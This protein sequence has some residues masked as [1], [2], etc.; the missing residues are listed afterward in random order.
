[1]K[2]Q[3]VIQLGA[4]RVDANS[5]VDWHL[6]GTSGSLERGGRIALGGL[7]GEVGAALAECETIV[8][9]PGELVFLTSAHIPSRQ[10]RQIKQALPYMVEELIADNIEDVHLAI[11]ELKPGD[12]HELPV[13][14]VQHH[15]LIDWLDQLY[16]HGITAE[17]L[18]PDMLAVPWRQGSHSFFAMADRIICRDGAYRGQV[19]ARSQFDNY[20][21]LLKHELAERELG[22]P[23]RHV[24]YCGADCI[25]AGQATCAAL[26]AAIDAET[27]LIEYA[28]NSTEVIAAN[29]VQH[30][31][32]LLNLLQGGYKVQR[33]GQD[34]RQ[35]ARV[36]AVAG[37]G[38]ALYCAIAGA[39]GAWFAWQADK[40]EAQTFS[41]Y[42][43]LFPGERRVVSPKKQMQAH[44]GGGSA[45]T[46]VS[47]LPL[48]AKAA[49]GL[50]GNEL[51]IDELHYRRQ[52]NELQLQLRAPTLETLDKVKTQLG[53]VGL[54]VEVN[55]ASQQGNGAVGRLNIRDGQS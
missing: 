7:P 4:P 10:V 25:E 11:P 28:E 5:L 24:V 51:Q 21:Q 14:V 1:M 20:L 53:G 22:A 3:L 27:S 55:S 17:V 26:Q 39:S 41:L 12:E 52:R 37:I 18:C 33:R 48:L 43:E 31:D 2:Q 44:L 40:A 23:L 32:E 19:I 13:G 6:F 9:V 30:V 35:W 16:Q 50:R 45:S 49:L 46:G 47:P 29:A 34:E 38:L 8:L 36:A 15:L 42:R 54:S